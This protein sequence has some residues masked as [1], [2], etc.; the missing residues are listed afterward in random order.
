MAD[1]ENFCWKFK[2]QLQSTSVKSQ[3]DVTLFLQRNDINVLA[4]QTLLLAKR[5]H[6]KALRFPPFHVEEFKL[7]M[8]DSIKKLCLSVAQMKNLMKDGVLARGVADVEVNIF[9]LFLY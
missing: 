3:N 7:I 4:Q 5:K 6:E 1:Y 8:D 2:G 9:V